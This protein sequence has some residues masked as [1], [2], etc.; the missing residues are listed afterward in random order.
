VTLDSPLKT[1]IEG[2]IAAMVEG[3]KVGCGLWKGVGCDREVERRDVVRFAEGAAEAVKCWEEFYQG[4]EGDGEEDGEEESDSGGSG[5]DTQDGAGEEENS[6]EAPTEHEIG[7][8]SCA[9]ED[10][11]R[12]AGVSG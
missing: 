11:G 5:D 9:S 1:Y 6:E 12:S 2:L 8:D 4:G 7:S 10:D 3:K